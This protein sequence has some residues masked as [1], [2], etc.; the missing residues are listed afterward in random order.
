MQLFATLALAALAVSVGASDVAER[1]C[2]KALAKADA[3]YIAVSGRR[4]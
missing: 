1:S 3:P 4:R 2:P